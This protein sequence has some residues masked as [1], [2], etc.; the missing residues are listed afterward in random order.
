MIEPYNYQYLKTN[1]KYIIKKE[2]KVIAY[3][4]ILKGTNRLNNYFW[5]FILFVFGIG[6]FITGLSSYLNFQKQTFLIFN[7][8]EIEYL[9]QGI[10][11]IFYGTCS[12]LLSFL[13]LWLIKLNLGSGVNTYD[14]ESKV[15]RIT[16]KNFPIFTNKFQLKSSN[17]YLVYPFSQILKIELE[18]LSGLNPKRVIYL[19]LK[20]NRRIPLTLSNQLDELSFLEE[21]AIFIAKVLK[22]D[23]KLN[24][25]N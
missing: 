22:V 6:F 2:G 10:L 14:I 8:T 1:N 7:F 23:L 15:I 19:I 18:L 24:I 17:I 20:D 11:L 5:S 13:I 4:E 21:R 16:R 12:I 25:N 9:P 3:S